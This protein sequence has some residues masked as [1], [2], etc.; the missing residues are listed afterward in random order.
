MDRRRLPERN[1]QGGDNMFAPG[2]CGVGAGAGRCGHAA[3]I[4]GDPHP[5]GVVLAAVYQCIQDTVTQG[6]I[7]DHAL[8]YVALATEVALIC[9]V[10][11]D[12]LL[13]EAWDTVHHSACY[14]LSGQLQ[15]R[16]RRGFGGGKATPEK[17]FLVGFWRRS[18]QK[19]TKSEVWGAAPA[20]LHQP[21]HYR[22]ISGTYTCWLNTITVFVHLLR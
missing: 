8:A 7:H 10:P 5:V 6:Q 3:R 20:T 17:S 22:L 4:K 1:E 11:E 21:W 14:F 2:T 15:R 12:H 16:L 19:P 13:A 18:R 9:G